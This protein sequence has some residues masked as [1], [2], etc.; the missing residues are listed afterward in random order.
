MSRIIDSIQL[1]YYIYI[2]V[3]KIIIV[4]PRYY[5]LMIEAPTSLH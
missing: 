5:K 1:K 2:V 4:D 3:S